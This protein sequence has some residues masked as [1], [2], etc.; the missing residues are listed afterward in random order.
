HPAAVL[1]AELGLLGEQHL[2][3]LLR[4]R[5]GR[6]HLGLL[7]LGGLRSRLGCLL[8]ALAPA[9]TTAAHRAET[10][11]VGRAA[12]SASRGTEP[13]RPRATPAGLV[14]LSESDVAVGADALVALGHDLT[15]V[16]PD[17]DADPSEGGL[18]LGESVVDV[19]PNR[20]QRNAALGVAL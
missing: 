2:R 7:L 4:L 12:P 8:G 5:L 19:R 15:L 3:R 18:R 11:A 9:G 1:L 16:D 13:L 6:R 10:F 20:V 14:L 17:L